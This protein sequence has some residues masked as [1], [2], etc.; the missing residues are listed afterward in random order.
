MK[1]SIQIGNTYGKFTVIGRGF[2]ETRRPVWVCRCVCG[3]E[4]LARDRKLLTKSYSER[5]CGCDLYGNHPLRAMWRTMWQRCTEQSCHKYKDYG[6]RGISVCE[7]WENFIDFVSDMGQKPPG[8]SIDRIDN[9]GNYEP[10]NCRWASSKIQSRNKRSSVLVS[11]GGKSQT[12]ADWSDE[13]GI[14]YMA[15]YLRIFRRKMDVAKALTMPQ[16]RNTSFLKQEL[17]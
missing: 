11:H 2:S 3:K 9:D 5:S 17:V 16:R 14:S 10:G 6:A 4:V 13:T 8:T 1:S 12:L 15:L 7:R